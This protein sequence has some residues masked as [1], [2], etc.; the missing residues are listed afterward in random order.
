[1]LADQLQLTPSTELQGQGQLRVF[2]AN[3][4][5]IANERMP[6]SGTFTLSTAGWATGAYTVVIDTEN[7]HW[8]APFVKR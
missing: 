7:L 5:L 3:G 4:Q 2:G 8:T 6:A 1:V